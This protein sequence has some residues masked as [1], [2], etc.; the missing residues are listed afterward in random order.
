MTR[1]P[2]IITRLL[3]R[4]AKR[5]AEREDFTRP[6]LGTVAMVVGVAVLLMWGGSP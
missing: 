5:E 4:R 6:L 1:H 2:P 3:E